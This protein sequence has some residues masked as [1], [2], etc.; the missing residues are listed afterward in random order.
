MYIGI[1][2]DKLPAI[3][4]QITTTRG[5]VVYNNV[6]MCICG[7]LDANRCFGDLDSCTCL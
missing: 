1:L 4:T 7:Q 2:N 5:I 3:R 6:V